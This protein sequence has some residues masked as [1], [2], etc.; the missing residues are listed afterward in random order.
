MSAPR[1]GGGL[2]KRS[3][4]RRAEELIGVGDPASLRYACLELR[5]CMELLAYAKL[6]VYANRIP[7][8]VY[9]AWQPPQLFRALEQIEPGSTHNREIRIGREVGPTG[10][11]PPAMSL[12]GR[13]VTFRGNELRKL[14][15][16]VGSYLHAPMPT[17]TGESSRRIPTAAR[18]RDIV[19]TIRPVVESRI[20]G[21]LAELFHFPC[22]IC[23]KEVVTNSRGAAAL[24]RA[25][26][27]SPACGAVYHIGAV[28]GV[29]ERY[30]LDA[31]AF[32]CVACG[33]NTQVENRLLDIGHQFDCG[34]CGEQHQFV[35][36]Q[37]GFALV[38]DLEA[39]ESET[40]N[41]ASPRSGTH[42]DET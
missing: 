8:S 7:P 19:E 20:D 32:E 10:P 27:L 36:R 11:P 3:T 42:G 15:N 31:T 35:T 13:H 2:D 40:E 12:L 4:L 1:P 21:G 33:H 37:W 23:G 34:E 14:Y 9:R 17:K 38:R 18:L 41:D 22:D 30:W 5:M 29:A 24:G 6:Q 16:K 28:D 26:C 39:A 25:E